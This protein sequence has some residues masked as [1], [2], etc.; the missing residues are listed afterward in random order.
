[1]TLQHQLRRTLL[2]TVLVGGV[3][4]AVVAQSES[5]CE[6]RAAA[7]A[8][9]EAAKAVEPEAVVASRVDWRSLLPAG[10]TRR[11]G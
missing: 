3:L 4:G 7:D 10:V 6:T 5:Y 8:A 9:V 2:S 11:P 1:M